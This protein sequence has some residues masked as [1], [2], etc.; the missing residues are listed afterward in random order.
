MTLVSCII[1][2]YNRP[3]VVKRAIA[4]ALKQ[5]Y[6]NIEVIVVD[7]GSTEPY[8]LT[9][10]RYFK[11]WE[12]N[13]GGS[14]A[15]N[16]GLTQAKGEYIVFI[17]DDNELH[18]GFVEKTLAVIQQYDVEAVTT[19]R[20][21]N[22]GDR[23][24]NAIPTITQFPAIDW[25]WLIKK[26]VFEKI[27]YDEQIWGDEDADMGIQFVKQDYSY[28]VTPE[29]LQT[30]YALPEQDATANTYPTARR[31]QGL[32]NFLNKNLE[33]YQNPNERRYILRLA[34]RNYLRA[35]YYTTAIRYFWQSLMAV[36]NLKTALHLLF[37]LGGWKVYDM[38]MSY[39]E[40]KV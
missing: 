31:L 20:V 2:T 36:K 12:K 10:V 28:T 19:G 26:K 29:L 18:A 40:R 37:A 39:E 1:P 35:G 27:K 5:T 8:N 24:V 23:V 14:A 13:R 30:A 11:P 34:G 16:Y 15:R 25:G 6:K 33:V 32:T 9:G 21:V 7:D 3:E 22:Y 17:D 38:Y 4:S